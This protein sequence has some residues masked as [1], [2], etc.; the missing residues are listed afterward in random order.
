MRVIRLGKRIE[1][2]LHLLVLIFLVDVLGEAI[3]A[4]GNQLRSGL[5]RMFAQMFL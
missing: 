2:E 3:V 1:K 4:T 5:D